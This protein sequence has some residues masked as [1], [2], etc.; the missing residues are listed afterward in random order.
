MN[1]V[2]AVVPERWSR[3]RGH[4]DRQ[5]RA[6]RAIVEGRHGAEDG[7]RVEPGE[8]P[9]Q[10][11]PALGDDDDDAGEIRNRLGKGETDGRDQ[12]REVVAQYLDVMEAPRQV[13][14][15]PAERIGHRLGLVMVV[16]AGEV[17]PAR[18]AAELDQAGAELH[19][20]EQPA[21]HPDHDQRRSHPGRPQEDP[22]KTSLQ[23]Q[24]FPAEGIEGLPDIGDRQ[25]ERPEREPDQHPHKQGRRVDQP[26]DDQCRQGDAKRSGGRQ[27]SVGVPKVKKTGGLPEGHPAE[28]ARGR[29]QA[30]LAEQRAKL[31]EG[32]QEGDQV[33]HT[34]PAGDHQPAQPVVGGVQ[35][36]GQG[37][38][39][40]SALTIGWVPD[41][42]GTLNA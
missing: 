11:Q 30:S 25:I 37:H 7:D 14:E 36:V 12:L 9:A 19:P 41:G 15:E 5:D 1:S 31:I 18:I 22:Q 27:E 28:K 29:K 40:E 24:R 34:Q 3:K 4:M 32:D 39:R 33:D 17:P 13:V 26:D 2:D 8:I 35:P 6:E 23:Q 38:R 10:H 21:E 20:E 16:E 42:L